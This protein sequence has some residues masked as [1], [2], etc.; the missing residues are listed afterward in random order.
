MR[1]K[2]TASCSS[3]NFDEAHETGRSDFIFLMR[4]SCAQKS[5]DGKRGSQ[6]KEGLAGQRS[7]VTHSGGRRRASSGRPAAE[8]RRTDGRTRAQLKNTEE[9]FKSGCSTSKKRKSEH[10]REEKR[11]I[12]RRTGIPQTEKI[13][14]C[15]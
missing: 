11:R 14:K 1:V 15:H 10:K 12:K 4:F 8:T 7:E 3:S 9:G 2:N 13:E 6:K 5:D